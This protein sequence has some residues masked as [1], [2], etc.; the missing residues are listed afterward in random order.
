MPSQENDFVTPFHEDEPVSWRVNP[1]YASYLIRT[2]DGAHGYRAPCTAEQWPAIRPSF[3]EALAPMWYFT[4]RGVRGYMTAYTRLAAWALERGLPMIVE[5]LLSA[6]VTEAYLAQQPKGTT[7]Q[8]NYLRKL[9]RVHGIAEPED[10]IGYQKRKAPAPYSE[11]ECEALVAFADSMTNDDRRVSLQAL[12][13]LGLGCGLARTG[14]R[15]VTAA[16]RHLHGDDE[17]VRSGVHCA[18]AREGYRELLRQVC[19]ERPEGGLLGETGRNITTNIVS[20]VSGRVGVPHLSPDRLR[21]TYICRSLEG[22]AGLID[23]VAWT[24]VKRPESIA[25]YFE[26]VEIAPQPCPLAPW[27]RGGAK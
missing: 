25:V 13:A 1:G 11:A 2:Y 15:G 14:L 27:N 23:I 19:E 9:A 17:Y 4:D 7:D 6:E 26:Y 22:G 18:K 5:T 20:W 3:I 21:A 16:S 10:P 12:L 24:G 8:R